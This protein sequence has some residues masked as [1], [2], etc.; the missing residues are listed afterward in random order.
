MSTVFDD[1]ANEYD[2]WFAVNDELYRSELDA[3]Q[4]ML[5]IDKTYIEV[6][7]GTGLF[8][9][10]LGIAEGVE[11]CEE[12]AN[13]A[14]RRGI[15]VHDALAQHLPYEDGSIEG[16]MMV[17]VDCFVK[18]IKAVFDEAYRVL[19]PHGSYVMAFL[20]RSTPLGQV[21]EDTKADNIYYRDA[22]F[23]SADEMRELLESS[24]LKVIDSCESV[25]T[26][27]NIYQPRK[28]GTGNGVFAIL[29]AEKEI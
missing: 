6:G 8:A 20:D 19:M 11:P 5:D 24:G 26:L 21:Y 9:S 17:T 3:L 15:V 28:A 7:V 22:I 16:I 18:D 1:N 4:S 14:R 27:D 13:I 12:M 2:E 23:R 10:K 29:K 25:Y